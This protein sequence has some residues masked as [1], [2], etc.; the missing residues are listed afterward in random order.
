MSASASVA[1]ELRHIDGIN[2]WHLNV[3]EFAM[4]IGY[5]VLVFPSGRAYQ[6]G[7][8]DAQ[9]AHV[10]NKNHLYIGLAFVGTF[11]AR[12]APSSK[13]LKAAAQVIVDSGRP[14]IGSHKSEQFDTACP[15]G[16]NVDRV[17]ANARALMPQLNVAD[18]GMWRAISVAIGN[19]RTRW[20][21]YNGKRLVY[22]VEL[23]GWS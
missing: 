1:D 5:H 23:E 21:R 7:V 9:R 2:R 20:V 18:M 15:G 13:M 14:V 19:R 17:T 6:V 10:K 22:E 12:R 8:Y 4:G 11:T 3:R 16:W